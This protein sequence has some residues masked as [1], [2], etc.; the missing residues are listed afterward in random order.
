MC[1]SSNISLDSVDF[2]SSPCDHRHELL[3]NHG[4]VGAVRS[5]IIGCPCNPE[6]KNPFCIHFAYK[7]NGNFTVTDYLRSIGCTDAVIWKFHATQFITSL[8]DTTRRVTVKWNVNPG[9]RGDL[10]ESRGILSTFDDQVVRGERDLS[11]QSKRKAQLLISE[12]RARIWLSVP[13]DGAVFLNKFWNPVRMDN[14][15]RQFS[16]REK[17]LQKI[18][19]LKKS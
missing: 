2:R 15:I 18:A 10:E 6:G 19:K 14:L 17:V 4:W 9:D 16:V 5:A 1:L 13:V 8:L 3:W 11:F 7:N 12:T